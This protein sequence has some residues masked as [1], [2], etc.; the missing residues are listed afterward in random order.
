MRIDDM[1]RT[2]LERVEASGDEIVARA[3]GWS[4]IS[5]GSRNLEGLIQQKGRLSDSF[6][7]LPGVVEEVRLAGSIEIADDGKEVEQSHPEALRIV[8]RPHADVQVALTGHYDTV[9]PAGTSFDRVTT[10]ADGALSGPGIADMKGGLSVMLAALDAFEAHPLS[11][12][13]G[14]RV[15][16]SPDEEIG[17]LASAPLLH[18]IGRLA[19]V[20][21][22]YEPAMADGALAA[23]RKGSGNFH[24]VVKGRAAHA[25]RDFASGRNAIARAAAIA[26]SLHELNGR[27]DGVT[28]NVARIAGGGPLNVVPDTAVVRFN[29]RFPDQA[30]AQRLERELGGLLREPID[31]GLTASLHG[32]FTRPAKPFD[33][34]QAQLFGK[35]REAAR[36]LSLDLMWRASGGVCEGNNLHAAGLPN[37]DTLGVRGGDIHSPAEHAW[38]DSFVERTQ[39]SALILMKLASGE[40]DAPAIRRLRAEPEA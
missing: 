12:R 7:A 30:A 25:G 8:V 36:S 34:A 18:E 39:L 24:V 9:Y 20:G 6:S 13:V 32:G 22:T 19:H 2:V 27:W 17:S 3:I 16:L 31:S 35:V 29:V 11:G 4:N 10:R 5:S 40:I 15:L 21:L 37:I 14:Y 38:P 23:A 33:E 26:S 28:I 1:E